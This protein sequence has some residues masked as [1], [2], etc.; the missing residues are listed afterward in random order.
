MARLNVHIE[1]TFLIPTAFNEAKPR[2]E[3]LARQHGA[4]A[5]I[6]IQ[7]KKFRLNETFIHNVSATAIAFTN[8]EN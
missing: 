7:E 4:D 1:K 8:E 3:A 6:N 2:L 5:L